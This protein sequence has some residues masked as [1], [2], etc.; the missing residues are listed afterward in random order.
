MKP[1]ADGRTPKER[2]GA[3]FV[4]VVL[5]RVDVEKLSNHLLVLSMMFF[6]FCFKKINTGFAESHGD[7]DSFFLKAEFLWWGKEVFDNLD[8][9]NRTFSVFCFLSHKS[10]FL[11]SNIRH[12]IFE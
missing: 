7:L 8:L 4:L 10:F 6:C 1:A 5:S 3:F 2:V 11:S 9:S 12:Q